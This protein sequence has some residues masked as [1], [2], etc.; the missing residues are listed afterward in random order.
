MAHCFTHITMKFS[1]DYFCF[2]SLTIK[3]D[4]VFELHMFLTT[5]MRRKRKNF[6]SLKSDRLGETGAQRNG[7]A[8]VLHFARDGFSCSFF[9]RFAHV[10]IINLEIIDINIVF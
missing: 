6:L 10:N 9:S 1:Y 3:M 4:E 8:L 5:T 2:G 7:F